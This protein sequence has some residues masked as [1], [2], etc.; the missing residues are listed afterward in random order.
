MVDGR[1]TK[2]FEAKYPRMLKLLHLLPPLILFVNPL[3]GFVS[4][5]PLTIP[6]IVI[7][8]WLILP[9]W[10]QI[11]RA[12]KVER[13]LVVLLLS[14]VISC[15]FAAGISELVFNAY[16]AGMFICLAF[17]IVLARSPYFRYSRYIMYCIIGMSV[18]LLMSMAH[19]FLFFLNSPAMFVDF[20]YSFFFDDKSHFSVYIGLFLFI[21]GC[22][23]DLCVERSSE[24]QWGSCV[25]GP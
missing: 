8:A 21:L 20:R 12:P 16:Y 6:I 4:E 17:Y 1:D 10:L 22:G 24:E 11:F 15:F 9:F 25:D 2:M 13:V 19:Y 23:L 5:A 3:T 14:V 18:C 7:M